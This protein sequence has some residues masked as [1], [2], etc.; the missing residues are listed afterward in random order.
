M[1]VHVDH[2]RGRYFEHTPARVIANCVNDER[3]ANGNPVTKRVWY[4]PRSILRR[5]CPWPHRLELPDG[6][7]AWTLIITQKKERE[8]GFRTVCG[9]I[10]WFRYDEAKR[11][12]C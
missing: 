10:P 1:V 6:K 3:D 9:W 2:S 4:G 7:T 5:P 11:A 12:D 8:W